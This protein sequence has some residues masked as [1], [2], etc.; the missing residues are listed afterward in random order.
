MAVEAALR[1]AP[2]SDYPILIANDEFYGGLGGRYAI[3]TR[4]L[5]SGTMV[6]RHELGHNFGQVGEEYDG[7]QV[8]SGANHSA[9]ALGG[10]PWKHWLTQPQAAT[11]VQATDFVSG[12]YLWQNL[13]AGAAK[14]R[15]D[16]PSSATTGRFAGIISAVGWETPDDVTAFLDGQRVAMVGEFGPDRTF[17]ELDPALTLAPGSH[18]LEF[19]EKIHDGDNVLAFAMLYSFDPGYDDSPDRVAAYPTFRDPG[20]S[21]GYRPTHDSCLMREMRSPRFCSVDLENMWRRFLS[22]ISLIDSLSVR[23]G[24]VTLVAPPLGDGLDV[25]WYRLTSGL[26]PGSLP[27]ETELPE[28]AG[29][30]EWTLDPAQSSMKY[31]VRVRFSTP[32]VRQTTDRFTASKDITVE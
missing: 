22:Q 13:S 21:S 9:S 3:T 27:T 19:A 16:F 4:S 17:F 26:F 24:V 10:L 6:L 32:E 18:N 31:R 8:Y 28:L 25:R 5:T 15:F 23:A 12:A 20:S 14:V 7:G 11:Q 29:K 2:A 30:Y 1:L